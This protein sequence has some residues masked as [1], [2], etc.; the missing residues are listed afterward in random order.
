M[1]D[2]TSAAFIFQF[3]QAVLLI[4]QAWWLWKMM[5]VPKQTEELKMR[6][7]ALERRVGVDGY[8]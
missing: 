3:F 8:P 1:Q 2:I 7:A 6:V 5:K 4:W